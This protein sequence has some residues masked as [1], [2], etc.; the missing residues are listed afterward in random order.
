MF[1]KYAPNWDFIGVTEITLE[2][3][4]NRDFDVFYSLIIKKKRLTVER[5]RTTTSKNIHIF[6]ISVICRIMANAK[7]KKTA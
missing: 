2:E 3:K 4:K 6:I 5:C 1:S 7:K